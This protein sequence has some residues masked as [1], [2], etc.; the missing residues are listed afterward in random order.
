MLQA[1]SWSCS[2]WIFLL[3]MWTVLW[4]ETQIYY[5]TQI[6]CENR[7]FSLNWSNVSYVRTLWRV[8]E[9]RWHVYR[10]ASANTSTMLVMNHND[11]TVILSFYLCTNY[12][13]CPSF[14]L[15][16]CYSSS[17][18]LPIFTLFVSLS[19][20]LSL[21]HYRFLSRSPLF[22]KC[23]NSRPCA[24]SALQIYMYLCRPPGEKMYRITFHRTLPQIYATQSCPQIFSKITLD[25]ERKTILYE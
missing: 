4:T 15:Q 13:L 18:L 23:H 12:S 24:H 11:A 7:I 14:F 19:F 9:K 5:A 25:V 20:F 21:S 2:Y 16:Y 3:D 6:Y 1:S 22:A 17:F 8:T 10:Q